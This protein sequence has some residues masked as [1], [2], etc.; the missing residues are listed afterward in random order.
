MTSKHQQLH[1]ILESALESV[2]YELVGFEWLRQ[3]KYSLLRVYIDSPEG[4]S[5]DQITEA[6]RQISAVL[7][8]EDPISGKYNLEVSSPGLNRPLF[9]QE[10]YERFVGQGVKLRLRQPIDNQRN[11]TGRLTSVDGNT[12]VV[13]AM[14]VDK[15]WQLSIND[16]EKANL[17]AEL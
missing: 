15:E 16:I 13:K 3:G 4:V 10:H 11:I 7:D 5:L 8:V 2:G 6:S 9:K 17:I 12:I 14:D 1:D